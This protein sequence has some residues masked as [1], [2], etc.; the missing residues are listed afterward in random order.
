VA[1]GTHITS[2]LALPFAVTVVLILLLIWWQTKNVNK[3][4]R[5]SEPALEILG[6]K[7]GPNIVRGADDPDNHIMPVMVISGR[8]QNSIE[9]HVATNGKNAWIVRQ[10]YKSE[11][12]IVTM[13]I[14][15]MPKGLKETMAE[16]C[17]EDN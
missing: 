7:D 4:C 17:V 1:C 2:W 14:G 3:L 6:H 13:T 8:K 10:D 16:V 12:Y 11:K 9:S 15:Y 5:L